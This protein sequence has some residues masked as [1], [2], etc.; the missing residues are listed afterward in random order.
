[1]NKK[2]KKA[3]Y[4]IIPLMV[5]L[6]VGGF[7]FLSPKEISK[8][9]YYDSATDSCWVNKDTPPGTAFDPAGTNGSV[10]CCFNQ[11]GEQVDCTDS[12]IKLGPKKLM[13]VYGQMGGTGS[14]GYFSVLHT[15]IITNTGNFN[16]DSFTITSATW[17][18]GVN[19]TTTGT[20]ALNT[21]W[22]NMV[23]KP[24][25]SISPGLATSFSSNAIDLQAIGAVKP[26]TANYNVSFVVKAVAYGGQ[27][28]STSSA[29][30]A[31]IS[32]Q[33]EDIGFSINFD[34]V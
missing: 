17:T 16:V 18:A 8:N 3:I 19:G 14:P 31:T 30:K 33:R 15:I 10:S 5:I 25:S 1:M 23:N 29:Q 13:A 12:S 22:S 24:S 26:Y 34:W 7:M 27:L 4:L 28:N 21:A 2:N 11:A 32:S 9:G 6:L 20:S